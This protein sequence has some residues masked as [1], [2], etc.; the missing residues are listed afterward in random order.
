MNTK[1][2]L[3]DKPWHLQLLVFGLVAA[4]LYA[5][6]W[7]FVTK[8]TRDQTAE[9]NTQIE[10]LQQANAKAQVA[11]Q[12]IN[13]F[14]AAYAGKQ[15]EYQELVVLLPEQRELTN[16]LQGLQD[17]ARGQL[18]VRRFTP[19]DDV[20][21]DFYSGKPIEIEV[22]GSYNKLGKFFA[23]MAAYQRI[24]SITDFNIKQTEDQKTGRTVDGQFL[25]TAYYVSPAKS[26]PEPEAAKT[27]KKAKKPATTPAT[28]A[29]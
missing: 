9:L 22:S 7:Y 11:S 18:S 13:D 15:A 2:N 14:R 20:Q 12:R 26:E 8:G 10:Q 1:S 23:Q 19:K 5:G 3:F 16:V 27:D 21:Q 29:K 6:F 4:V 17:R 28:P 24:V 25:M